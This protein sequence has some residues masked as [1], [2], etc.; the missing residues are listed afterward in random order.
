MFTLGQVRSVNIMM[1]IITCREQFL[2]PRPVPSVLHV[3]T[4]NFP[5]IPFGRCC[6]LH[7]TDGKIDRVKRARIA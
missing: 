3:L 7:F 4:S 5:P 2:M 1:V 6:N